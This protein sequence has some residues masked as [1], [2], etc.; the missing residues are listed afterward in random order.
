MADGDTGMSWGWLIFIGIMIFIIIILIGINAYYWG[1]ESGVD[2]DVSDSTASTLY[3]VNLI[4]AVII[5]IAIIIGLIFWVMS[6]PED[7]TTQNNAAIL[8]QT[9]SGTVYTPVSRVATSASGAPIITPTGNSTITTPVE[10]T[11]NFNPRMNNMQ[12]MEPV[13]RPIAFSSPMDQRMLQTPVVTTQ[14]YPN[15]VRNL[16]SL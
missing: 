4:A 5:I 12:Q 13:Y 15:G 9:E 6:G 1:V 10:A 7:M 3:Y 8:T 16:G 14:V 2:S 11:L